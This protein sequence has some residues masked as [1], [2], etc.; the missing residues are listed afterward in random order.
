MREYINVFKDRKSQMSGIPEKADG[1]CL[2]PTNSPI[3][4]WE[5]TVSAKYTSILYIPSLKITSF[6]ICHRLLRIFESWET[7]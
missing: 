1:M 2:E 5:I 3:I 4:D 6:N 7:S